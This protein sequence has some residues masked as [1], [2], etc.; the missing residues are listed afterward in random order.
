MIFINLYYIVYMIYIFTIKIIG[1]K[2]NKRI[3]SKENEVSKQLIG[4]T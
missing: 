4:L 3:K 1:W 2:R